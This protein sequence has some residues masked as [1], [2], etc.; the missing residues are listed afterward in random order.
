ML[1]SQYQWKI[2]HP[3]RSAVNRLSAELGISP[4]LAS[5]LANRGYEAPA[6]AAEFLDGDEDLSGLHDPFLLHGMDRAVQRIRAALQ[7]GERIWI[8]GDYDADGVSST[9]LMIRL[10]ARMEADF[11]T[12]IP[13]RSKEG[14]GLHRHAID[15]AASEGVKLI[16]TVDT[17]ISAVDQIAYASSLGI[18]VVVTDHHEPPAVLPEACALVNP[19]LPMCGYPFKGL[20]GVGVAFKLSHALLGLPPEE[21]MDLTAIGTVADLMPL[22]GENRLIVARGIEVMRRSPSPGVE[23]LLAVAGSKPE[24]LT[25]VGI[26]FAIAPRINASGRLDHADRAVDLLTT[27]ERDRAEHLASV[28]DLLNKERQ[29]NVED[30]VSEAIDMLE[31]KIAG[32]GRVPDV[33]VLA[34]EGWNVGVVGIV[35][36]KI[37]ERYYRPTIILG[38]DAEKGT[39]KGSARSIPGFDIYEALLSV[40]ETMQHFGG[41]PSAA[42]M[43]LLSERLDDFE[44]GLNQHAAKVLKAEHLIP[45]IEAETECALADVPIPVIEELERMAP[46]GMNNPTPQFVFRGVKLQR[47]MTMGKTNTHLKLIVEQDGFVLEAVAFGKGALAE[48]LSEGDRL[49]LLAEPGINEWR[50]SRKPQLMVRDLALPAFQ[51]F[52]RRSPSASADNLER[53]RKKAET[54]LACRP[55]Q[56]AAAIH[57]T[58]L[59]VLQK[60]LAQLPVWLYDEYSG[61]QGTESGL[62]HA[63]PAG[64]RTLFVLDLPDTAAQLDRLL[65]GL[66]SLENVVLLYSADGPEDGRLSEPSRERIKTIYVELRRSAAEAAD[67]EQLVRRLSR[68]S[69]CSP[70]MIRMTLDVFEELEFI[71]RAEGAVTA[72]PSPPKAALESAAAYRRLQEAE[73]L[74]RR[75]LG[76]GEDIGAWL[77]EKRKAAGNGSADEVLSFS[78]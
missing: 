17:G 15:Q 29:K 34:G 71:V 9:A 64:T 2:A 48:Y 70:R 61:I 22:T 41:H 30:I 43:S 58:T 7:G 8:Y 21:W 24:Q 45:V 65:A 51:V 39:C 46:F 1:H 12:Y 49:D 32:A 66:P 40:E 78:V 57:K 27:Q 35:A 25:S 73:A 59:K 42:G 55:D 77:A 33:I 37:L 38:I 74:E 60:T 20:A 67:E 11:G 31:L 16:V 76:P 54:V 47:A 5:L 6:S 56:I 53:F 44:R 10:M 50:G 13:H 28:L 63:D 62:T 14:Y 36:S 69:G 23:E 3:D 68:S 4:L 52:D 18:D 72:N 26:A 75:L 19:K